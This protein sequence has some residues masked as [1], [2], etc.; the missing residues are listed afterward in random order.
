MK[1]TVLVLILSTIFVRGEMIEEGSQIE[2]N[3]RE[4]K[5]LVNRGVASLEV[6]TDVE[7]SEEENSEEE[8]LENTTKPIE[9]MT[10][11]ELLIYAAELNLEVHDQMTKADL[12]KLI[13][14]DEE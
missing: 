2:V 8:D 12:I 11:T 6:E 13:N 1:D 3:S 7:I 14:E 4:A 10:K 5:E 9:K